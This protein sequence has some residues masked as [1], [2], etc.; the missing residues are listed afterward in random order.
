MKREMFCFSEK[1]KG[2]SLEK[3]KTY[4]NDTESIVRGKKVRLFG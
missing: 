2:F 3:E 1:R 4:Q